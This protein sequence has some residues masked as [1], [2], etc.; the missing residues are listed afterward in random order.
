VIELE[1]GLEHEMS[2]KSGTPV[3]VEFVGLEGGL[4]YERAT[5]ARKMASMLPLPA[6]FI[7]V[8]FSDGARMLAHESVIKAV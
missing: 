5:V 3:Q 6:G 7:P 8:R 4:R 1:Q 2:I